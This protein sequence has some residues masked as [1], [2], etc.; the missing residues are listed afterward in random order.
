MTIEVHIAN[1]D[2]TRSIEVIEV[3]INQ[4]TGEHRQGAPYKLAPGCSAAV[5]T[6]LL[7]DILVREVDPH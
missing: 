4:A 5:H 7:R 1:K 6:H 3:T 2:K